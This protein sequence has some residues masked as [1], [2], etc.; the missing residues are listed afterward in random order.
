MNRR[1]RQARDPPPRRRAGRSRR[2]PSSSRRCRTRATTSSRRPSRGTSPSSASSRC[3]PRAAASSTRRPGR[4]TPTGC[5]RSARR[6][7][8]T[9]I[10]VEA[11][12]G[13]LVIVTTPLRLCQRARSGD[14]RGLVTRRSPARSP[15]TTRSSSPRRTERPRSELQAEL[16]R[17][18]RGRESRDD[19]LVGP[20]R[21][22]ARPGRVGVPARRRRAS[23][24]PTTARRR[25]QHAQRLHAAGLLSDDELAEAESTLA[26]IAQDPD[27]YL[28]EDEDV[29]SAIE[30]Q[31]GGVGRKIH[32]GRSRNDQVAA[33]FRLYVARRVRRG[34]RGDRRARARRARRSPR[35]RPTRSCPAT[36]TSSA[37]QPVTLGHHLLA[38]VEM[39]DRDR[40]RFAAAARRGASRARSARA[41]SPGR[42]SACPAPAGPDAQLDRRRRRPR[43]RARLPLRGAPCSTPTSR[44]SA[45]SSCSG[46]P[47]E[48]GFVEAARER[49]D[50][51][52]DD[53]AETQ[54]RRSWNSSAAKPA[55]CSPPD[56]HAHPDP[57]G[58]APSVQPRPAGGQ[59]PPVRPGHDTRLG[60][61]A[62]AALV[63][64]L[65][66]RPRAH[67][68]TRPPTRSCSRRTQPRRSFSEGVPFRE[69]HERVAASV[70]DG[71]FTPAGS[72]RRERRC[73]WRTRAG[74]RARRHW[75][76]RA[77]GSARACEHPGDEAEA[78]I[79]L[80]STRPGA[81]SSS[82]S[83]GVSLIIIDATIVNVAL[84][85]IIDDLDLTLTQAEW[86]NS[87]YALVFASLL[88]PL[89]PAR[90]RARPQARL[91]RRDRRL[92][93]RE[94]ARRARADRRPA[95]PRPRRPGRRRGRRP[96]DLALARQRD[97]PGRPP[98]RSPSACGAPRSGGW[99]R[100]GRSRAAR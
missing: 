90:R 61:Q 33:A 30:R 58:I 11:A 49:R 2:R 97:L 55:A 41:R 50:G 73:A 62:L 39:L 5:E 96:A 21:R 60:L 65:A 28:A 81:R 57:E 79:S 99:L 22:L 74:W 76:R 25:V 54:P 100:S 34:A 91:P 95:D 23:C 31:L 40:T 52:V 10:G 9:P 68:R 18:S 13:G 92:R 86:I 37:A 72:G 32:A 14:R 29:H 47:R 89:R 46:R 17:P 83:A 20:R 12:S 45:R 24:S 56:R 80:P 51:L 27:G 26:E 75:P 93:R 63:A 88:H 70:R 36:R 98:G 1:E 42:R 77:T 82:L 38:W 64:G 16:R 44:A 71:S 8:A 84:P 35:Q 87:I 48:F 4:A 43:L 7:D 94:P 67:G 59:G 53:A 15:A 3:A 78:R 19:P 69:A 66:G 6:C 85:T